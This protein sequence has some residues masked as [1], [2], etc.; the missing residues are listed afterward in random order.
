VLGEE[1]ALCMQALVIYVVSEKEAT[2]LVGVAVEVEEGE[3]LL[4]RVF[5]QSF[6][7]V[8][9]RLHGQI[10]QMIEAIQVLTQTI[11]AIV[12]IKDTIRV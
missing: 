3:Q 6:D 11:H 7:G 12:A 4:P 2:L 8:A 1:D 10:G 9:G 5:N